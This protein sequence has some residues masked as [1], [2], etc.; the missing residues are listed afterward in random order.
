MLINIKYALKRSVSIH[1]LHKLDDTLS[2]S[3]R[4][5]FYILTIVYQQR[6]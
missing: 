6:M 2:R 4:K 1:E 3:I 5:V